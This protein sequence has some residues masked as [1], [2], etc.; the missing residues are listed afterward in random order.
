MDN[1]ELSIEMVPH[2]T[3]LNTVSNAVGRAVANPQ[4]TTPRFNEQV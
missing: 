1:V 2:E 3:A 4:R